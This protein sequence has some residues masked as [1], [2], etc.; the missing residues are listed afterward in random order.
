MAGM[1]ALKSAVLS[2]GMLNSRRKSLSAPEKPSVWRA[3]NLVLWGR[4]VGKVEG[5]EGA[6]GRR[7]SQGGR[8]RSRRRGR[9][10]RS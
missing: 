1:S 10:C 4:G 3:R 8:S 2:E 5:G 6:Y 7:R 9:V